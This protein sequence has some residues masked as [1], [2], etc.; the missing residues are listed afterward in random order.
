MWIVSAYLID[1]TEKPCA[2]ETGIQ[3]GGCG[4][5]C[6]RWLSGNLT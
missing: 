5:A 4:K 6:E 3:S 2:P 1:E